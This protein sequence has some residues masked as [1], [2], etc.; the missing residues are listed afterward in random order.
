[1][2]ILFILL[3]I[4]FFLVIAIV[5]SCI[6]A[7]QNDQFED[8]EDAGRRILSEEENPKKEQ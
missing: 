7:T 1:M 5:G 6:W 2:E 4:T 3:P 8:F